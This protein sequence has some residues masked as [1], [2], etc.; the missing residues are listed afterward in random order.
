MAAWR[1]GSA[2]PTSVQM[3]PV[4]AGVVQ[5]SEHS[6]FRGGLVPVT[7]EDVDEVRSDFQEAVQAGGS[8]V[9]QTFD[10]KNAFA[11]YG[12]VNIDEGPEGV[13]VMDA[14]DCQDRCTLDHKC[15]CASF[16][17]SKLKCWKRRECVVSK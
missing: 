14:D 6:R 5:L 4:G 11:P 1:F 9:Y 16:D 7:S 17:G 15:D 2:G 10:N 13:D 12:A 3:A 8:V